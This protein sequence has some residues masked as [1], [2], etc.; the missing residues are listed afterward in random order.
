MT[1]AYIQSKKEVTVE[2][3]VEFIKAVFNA[4]TELERPIIQEEP[5]ELLKLR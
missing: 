5:K 1:V 4:L 2:E 3:V